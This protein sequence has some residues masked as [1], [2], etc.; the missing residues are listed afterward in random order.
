MRSAAGRALAPALPLRSFAGRAARSHAGVTENAW[1]LDICT[2]KF[3]TP[4]ATR[5]S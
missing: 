1:N 5:S 4:W 3:L 2:P